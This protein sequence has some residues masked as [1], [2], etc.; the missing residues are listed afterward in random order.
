MSCALF[1]GAAGKIENAA[2]NKKLKQ[3]FFY[4]PQKSYI[5]LALF[6]LF[7]MAAAFLLTKAAILILFLQD[8]IT[9]E[10]ALF[11]VKIL[12][13][14]VFSCAAI[15]IGAAIVFPYLYAKNRKIKIEQ[16]LPFAVNYMSA[17]AAAGISPDVIFQTMTDKKIK[18]VYDGL[19]DEFFEFQKQI[20]LMGKDIPGALQIIEDQ[21]PSPLF[22]N[23]IAGSKNTFISGSSFQKYIRS[24]KQEYQ[25]LFVRRKEKEIQ[26]LD[27][28]A[29]I[30]IT[31]FLAAPLFFIIMFY[32]SLS[33]SGPK[34]NEISLLTY[35]IVPFLGVFFHLLL[36]IIDSNNSNI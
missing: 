28:F 27:L 13:F 2:F 10:A 26:S 30:Y 19:Y 17:M 4:V 31:L 1:A 20:D 24:K 29:E 36:E 33:F 7:L 3:C 5:A 25:S 18:P 9:E 15:L 16:Q 35:A 14:A 11:F 6:I 32:A 8:H 12:T 23:F 34:I 21:T 22:S